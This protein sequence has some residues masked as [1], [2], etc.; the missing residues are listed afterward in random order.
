MNE[1]GDCKDDDK[2]VIRSFIKKYV[3]NAAV[4]QVLGYYSKC[5]GKSGSVTAL[6]G[7]TNTQVLVIV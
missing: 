6:T 3:W 2:G 1:P 5:V 7:F 4:C